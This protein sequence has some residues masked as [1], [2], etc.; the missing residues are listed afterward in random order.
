MT[1]LSFGTVS[2]YPNDFSK[3]DQP[4]F[5]SATSGVGNGFTLYLGGALTDWFTFGLGMTQTSFGSDKLVTKGGAFIFHVEAFPLFAKG[6]LYRDLG[7][8]AN[9][10][11]GT[12]TISRREGG[13]EFAASGSL[14]IAGVGALWETWRF[15]HIALGPFAQVQYEASNSMERTLGEVG[16]RGVFYGGP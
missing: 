15:W 8:F 1:G 12:A 16:I 11:T 3:I 13:Q 9:F 14:S 4:A 2:G 10:G 6:G 5:R 7:L